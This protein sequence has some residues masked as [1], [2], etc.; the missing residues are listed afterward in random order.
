M[1]FSEANILNYFFSFK[2]MSAYSLQKYLKVKGVTSH[3]VEK[4]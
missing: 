4:I 1:I 3:D 2:D